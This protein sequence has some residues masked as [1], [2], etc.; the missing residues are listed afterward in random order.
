M[1]LTISAKLEEFVRRKLRSGSYDSPSEIVEEALMLL[2]ERDF[3]IGLRRDHLLQELADGIFQANNRE[4]VESDQVFAQL[5]K[6][7]GGE[8][9]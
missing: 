4:L 7:D 3:A 5:R 1:I 9:A 2:E 6:Q 8:G